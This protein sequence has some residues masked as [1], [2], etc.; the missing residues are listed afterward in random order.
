LLDYVLNELLNAGV[1]QDP[2]TFMTMVISPTQSYLSSV[3]LAFPD[4]FLTVQQLNPEEMAWYV[5]G[6]MGLALL[7]VWLVIPLLIGIWRFDRA[8]IG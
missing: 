3:L 5:R 7:A 2:L 8:N 4:N 6:E 1:G